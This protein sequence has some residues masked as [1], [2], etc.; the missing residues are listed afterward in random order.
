MNSL[1]LFWGSLAA[2]PPLS[3]TLCKKLMAVGKP[4][5]D[6]AVTALVVWQ[7]SFHET[8][9]GESHPMYISGTRFGSEPTSSRVAES[10]EGPDTHRLTVI[11]QFLCE[12]R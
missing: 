6:G 3:G 10:H 1:K 4:I 2:K 12:F 5:G 9:T 8:A 11:S 7:F